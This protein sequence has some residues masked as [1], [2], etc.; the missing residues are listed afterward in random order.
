MPKISDIKKIKKQF[1]P[2]PKAPL[3]V[4]SA[5]KIA[6]AIVDLDITEQ[7]K[8]KI[9]T[10]IQ[11]LISLAHGKYTTKYRTHSV[12][13]GGDESIQHEHVFP[14]KKVSIRI[15][16]DTKN[17]EKY[18]GDVVG[19]VVTVKEHEALTEAE[20]IKPDLDGWERYREAGVVVY[21]MEQNP[22]QKLEWCLHK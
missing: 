8:K 14:R 6:K 11:W 16:S 12:L 21:D 4:A 7:H 15:L 17:T 5:I 2:S 3:K 10:E 19:C 1:I 9:L 20:K 18:L 22:P 13:F